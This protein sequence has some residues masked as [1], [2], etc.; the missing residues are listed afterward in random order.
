M[1]GQAVPPA[2]ARVGGWFDRGMSNDLEMV[3]VFTG[4]GGSGGSPSASFWTDRR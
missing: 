2:E 1:C 4:P 3:R